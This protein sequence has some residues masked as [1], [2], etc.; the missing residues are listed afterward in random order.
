MKIEKLQ[1][2]TILGLDILFQHFLCVDISILYIYIF[3]IYICILYN[4]IH[5]H[6]ICRLD[7]II[8]NQQLFVAEIGTSQLL[9]IRQ[10]VEQ[11]QGSPAKLKRRANTHEESASPRVSGVWWKNLYPIGS[12]YAI[13]GN[14]YHQYTSIYPSHVSIY[15]IY[16]SYGYG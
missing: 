4:I 2:T 16:G 13:Y 12:M 8:S 10:L 14:I 3:H 6:I 1:F 11:A 7:C 9:G 5:I 15:T